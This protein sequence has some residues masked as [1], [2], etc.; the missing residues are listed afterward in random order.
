MEHAASSNSD[1][2]FQEFVRETYRELV[3]NIPKTAFLL[4]FSPE[5]RVEGLTVEERLNGLSPE[6]RLRG[7]S[8]EELVRA[9]PPE[10][11]EV[12]FRIIKANASSPQPQ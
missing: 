9:L 3:Q 12:L 1:K 10:T 5:E 6:E 11:L 7:L 2:K 4:G 8:I